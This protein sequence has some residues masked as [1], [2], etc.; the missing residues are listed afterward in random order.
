MSYQLSKEIESCKNSPISHLSILVTAIINL[1]CFI[2]DNILRRKLFKMHLLL[3]MIITIHLSTIRLNFLHPN[4][5]WW[6]TM[7]CL[8]KIS[9]WDNKQKHNTDK[10]SKI[11][12]TYRPHSQLTYLQAN[13]NYKLRVKTWIIQETS[14]NNNDFKRLTLDS[15]LKF[16][17]LL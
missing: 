6:G 8:I 10:L 16:L 7:K 5:K 11:D 3:N 4:I 1:R 14:I 9:Y 17:F 12:A 2:K 15:I 13:G